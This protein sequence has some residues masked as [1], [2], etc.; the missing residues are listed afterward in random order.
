MPMKCN[1]SN[2]SRK[3]IELPIPIEDIANEVI[4]VD[5][6][7]RKYYDGTTLERPILCELCR[8]L[9]AYA[10]RTME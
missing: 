1:K 5:G 7:M 8:L 9:R 3:K 6:R 4:D 10:Y 2:N